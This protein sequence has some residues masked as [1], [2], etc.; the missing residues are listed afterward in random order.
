MKVTEIIKK[1]FERKADYISRIG[2]MDRILDK[3]EELGEDYDIFQ[4]L[5]DI[6]DFSAADVQPVVTCG[7]CKYVKYN[8]ESCFCEKHSGHADK[9]GEDASYNEYHSKH[10]FCAD[11]EER[12]HA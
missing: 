4:V 11:G 6:K 1:I 10:W 5:N 9:F 12:N 8:C 2:I 3:W 7:K